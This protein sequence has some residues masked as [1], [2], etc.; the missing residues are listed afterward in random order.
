MRKPAGI[1]LIALCALLLG[2]TAVLYAKYRESTANYAAAKNEGETTQ[3]HYREAINSI[4]AIQDSLSAIIVGESEVPLRTAGL[5]TEHRLSA[6]QA[7]EAMERIAVLKQGIERA[8]EKIQKLDQQ[9]KQS[10]IKVAGLQRM[11]T[12][13]KRTVAEKE[14]LADQLTVRVD[15]LQTTVTGLSAE[16]QQN[17]ETMQAQAVT[18]EEKRRELGTVYYV[19]GTKKELTKSGVVVAQGGVLGLGKT[20]K[21]SGQVDETS[22]TAIDTDQETTVRIPSAKPRVLSAQPTTSYELQPVGDRM[23]ELRITDPKEF[24]KVKHLVIMTT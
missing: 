11:I 21:P 19:I 14:Q 20:V 18:I 24:R 4:A 3:A 5:D 13:L 9:L 10:G 8:K 22:F 16:V 15:S 12:G 7:D 23:T 2:A 1:A 6:S 17:Q